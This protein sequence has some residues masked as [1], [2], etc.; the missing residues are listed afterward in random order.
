MKKEE[1]IESRSTFG[2]G[3]EIRVRLS[4]AKTPVKKR[5]IRISGG[6]GREEKYKGG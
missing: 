6:V 4:V 5:S 3:E 2:D 1:I